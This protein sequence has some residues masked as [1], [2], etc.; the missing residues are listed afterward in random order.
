MKDRNTKNTKRVTQSSKKSSKKSVPL[1]ARNRGAIARILLALIAL[2]ALIA[3][4]VYLDYQRFSTRPVLE[5]GEERLFVIAHGTSWGG[6]IDELRQHD[7]IRRRHYFDFWG[8][9]RGLPAEVKAGSYKLSGPLSLEELDRS[10][11][12]GG[13]AEGVSVTVPEGYNIYHMADRLEALDVV[14]RRA[15]L[16]AVRSRELLDAHGLTAESFE[17]YLFPDTYRIKQGTS[18]EAIVEKMYARWQEVWEELQREHPG[19]L[20]EHAE[21][22]EMGVHELVTLAS[23]VERETRHAPERGRISR[24]FLNR[25]DR[26]MRLQ[27]D[28]TCVYGEETY[29]EVPSPKRCKDKLNR[30]STYVIEG[31]PPGPIANP[32]KESLRAALR[33]E[34]GEDAREYLFFVARRD[35]SGSHYFS[36]SYKEHIAAID[37]YLRRGK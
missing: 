7:V 22:R 15:F 11:R 8:R 4:G 21:V 18:A 16:E 23:L 33:P 29:R 10:L 9:R 37:R 2:V 1:P 26:G 28:P 30:Y 31:L 6:V 25:I 27:T 32:G 19:A 24:V 12:Q 14:S 20:E 34:Q 5:Q 17:G 13:L 36:K 35:G 3:G